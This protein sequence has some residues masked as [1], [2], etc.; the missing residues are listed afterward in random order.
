MVNKSFKLGN[1]QIYKCLDT[2]KLLYFCWRRLFLKF[3]EVKI[4]IKN[5][6]NNLV[7]HYFWFAVDF[8]FF[9]LI[10]IEFL[11]FIYLIV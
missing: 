11:E 5:I 3:A 6:C 1:S 7:V 9:G 4:I 8:F 2:P 10:R